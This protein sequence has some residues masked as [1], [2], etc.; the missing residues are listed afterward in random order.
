MFDSLSGRFLVLTII[1][2]ML[3]EVLIFVPSIS[4]FRFEYLTERL[5]RA[6]I[7]SL[8]LLATTNDMVDAELEA[9]LLNNAGVLSIA[10][11]RDEIR[12]LILTSPMP[13]M[14]D[15]S[16]DLRGVG[17]MTLMADALRTMLQSDDRLIRVIGVPVKSGGLEIEVTMDDAPLRAAMFDYGRNIFLLSLLISVITAA[18]LFL[19]V[20]R[21]IVRPMRHVVDNMIGFQEN[22]ANA[23]MIIA[24]SA[25]ITELRNAE[26]ALNEMQSRIS[27]SLKQK[28][29]LA[30]LGEAVAKISHD[31]R[32]MLTTAQL[33]VD[34]IEMSK[35]PAVARTAPKL[36]GSLN[37][38][39]N[40][41]EQS[42]AF[43]KAEEAA[44]VIRDTPLADILRD[45]IEAE[46][47]RMTGG[48]STLSTDIPDA[49]S[50]SADPEQIYRVIINLC[51]NARQA[52]ENA[53]RPGAVTVS[54][55]ENR[56]VVEIDVADTG[57]GLPQKALTHLFKPFEGGTRRGGTGLGLAIAAE[58]VAGHGGKL[59]L[60]STSP[61]GTHF[62][63]TLPNS[64]R[65]G[66]ANGKIRALSR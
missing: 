48:H 14:I 30:Q 44:P 20:R 4:R 13:G 5:E 55:R 37:R 62:R 65:I 22:P 47:L 35:D 43:G 8:S 38:A 45:V 18:L 41:C 9:E 46:E 31:L 51:R 34:R 39:I 21:F 57:P 36:V 64:Q 6:Q 16:F 52:I 1:F 49:L 40:L 24:P 3:A 32:N 66:P 10:L 29:R 25:S 11:R 15:Q 60:I 33:M 17:A 50:I 54:A 26:V 42:L 7:A 56:D 2:V 28:D 12:E 27:A 19:A 58:L 53:G 59:E 61:E 63:I 23:H